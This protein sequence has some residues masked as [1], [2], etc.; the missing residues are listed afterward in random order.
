MRF[1]FSP[2]LAALVSLVLTP[3]VT[4]A[5]SPLDRIGVGPHGYDVLLGTWTCKNNAPSAME[6]PATIVAVISRTSTA[7]LTFHSTAANFDAMGY[8][9][10]D[11]KTKRWWNP[12][13]IATGGFGTESTTQTGP[14][15]VWAGHFTDPSSGKTMLIRDTYT[16]A[17][18]TA[19]T[20]LYESNAGGGWKTEGDSTCKRS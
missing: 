19:Y 9:V 13:M 18:A 4:P 3:A 7:A 1:R 5:A 15:T 6:G 20:D 17:N 2:L 11:P 8:I 16:F 10:Y 12:S 14:K